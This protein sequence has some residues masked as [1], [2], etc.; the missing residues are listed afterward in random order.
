[1][2]KYR[3]L[4]RN[5]FMVDYINIDC[6]IPD[7]IRNKIKNFGLAYQEEFNI[8]I[9]KDKT[10]ELYNDHYDIYLNRV[11]IT[12]IEF[13]MNGLICNINVATYSVRLAKSIK[14]CINQVVFIISYPLIEIYQSHKNVYVN[15]LID[16]Y[17]HIKNRIRYGINKK[18]GDEVIFDVSNKTFFRKSS[19]C[20]TITTKQPGS[21]K[22][23]CSGKSYRL[24]SPL[25][26]SSTKSKKQGVLLIENA[27]KDEVFEISSCL[28]QE[29]TPYIPKECCVTKKNVG[30][31]KWIKIIPEITS[32]VYSLFHYNT[33]KQMFPRQLVSAT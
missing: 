5:N 30:V 3:E 9:T 8:Y 33:I 4:Y 14:K 28:V 11:K 19:Q 1:M 25:M 10:R 21:P 26:T 18:I 2:Q 15:T 16:F 12:E 17:E 22:T 24:L 6:D 13:N 7:F 32:M 27:K 20:G 23:I 29:I 31:L